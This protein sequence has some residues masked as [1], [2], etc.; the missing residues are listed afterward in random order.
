MHKN[1]LIKALLSAI[2]ALTSVTLLLAQA[3]AGK[4]PAQSGPVCKHCS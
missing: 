3:P 1:T 4:G 2:C